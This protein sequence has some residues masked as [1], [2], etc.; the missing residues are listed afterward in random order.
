M[1]ALIE[2]MVDLMEDKVESFLRE[3]E[4]LADGYDFREEVRRFSD[5]MEQGL[6]GEKRSLQML[7]AYIDV[8]KPGAGPG[9]AGSHEDVLAIDAGGTNLRAALV[10]FRD[11]EKPEILA[12]EK[13]KIPGTEGA[14]SPDEFFDGIATSAAPYAASAERAGFCF[15]YASEVL[16]N[17]DARILYF[18]KEVIVRNAKGALLGE[19][20][21]AAFRRRGFAEKQIV[22]L[23]DTVA[24]LL[25]VLAAAGGRRDY[26]GYIGMVF[27]TGLNHCYRE[28]SKGMLINTESAGYA[29]FRRGSCDTALDKASANPGTQLLEKMVSGAYFGELA[30]RV[31]KAA[32]AEGLVGPETSARVRALETLKASEITAHLDILTGGNS[33]DRRVLFVLTE[34]LHDRA[35]KL[36]AICIAAMMERGGNSMNG[37]SVSGEPQIIVCEGSAFHK[38]ERFR[39][40]FEKALAEGGAGPY[41]IAAADDAAVLGAAVAALHG[42][43]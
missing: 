27:G 6:S 9:R 32:A 19:G 4:L 30:L 20:L 13:T 42:A 2:E 15:S 25:G 1:E 40:R 18:S 17:L 11:G 3:Q 10:R 31:M 24:A 33:A 38:R 43:L 41:E 14:I 29:G 22:V 5:D 12:Q 21:N 28:P 8:P 7:P 35:A 36:L 23:N 37:E 26:K 16:P 34:A 39:E